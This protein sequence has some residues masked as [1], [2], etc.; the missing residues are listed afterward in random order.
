MIG[1]KATMRNPKQQDHSRPNRQR[2]TEEATTKREEANP[3]RKLSPETRRRY[4]H[5]VLLT[6]PLQFLKKVETMAPKRHAVDVPD[7]QPDSDEESVHLIRGIVLAT[8]DRRLE[9][10]RQPRMMKKTKKR[11]RHTE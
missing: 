10:T 11:S 3:Q 6:S 1:K 5:H 4:S 9:S 8:R 2:E 7:E